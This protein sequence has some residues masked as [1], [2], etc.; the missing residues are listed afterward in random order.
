MDR[1]SCLPEELTCEIIRH[2]AHQSLPALVSI[3]RQFHRLVTPQLYRCVYFDGFKRT[4]VYDDYPFCANYSSAVRSAHRDRS[5]WEP[6]RICGLISFYKTILKNPHLRSYITVACFKRYGTSRWAMDNDVLNTDDIVFDILDL[7]P[8]LQTLEVSLVSYRFKPKIGVAL[9]SLKITHNLWA[10][11]DPE[12]TYLYS[13]F[14]IETLRNISIGNVAGRDMYPLSHRPQHPL[15]LATS[16][17]I[18]LSFPTGVPLGDDLAEF[19]LWPKALEVFELGSPRVCYDLILEN[20]I[21]PRKLAEVLSHH[22]HSLRELCITEYPWRFCSAE[23]D[24]A[25]MGNLQNFSVL[26]RLC[27]SMELMVVSTL[28]LY[29]WLGFEDN[30]SGPQVWESLPP[31][32]EE[33]IIRT[34]MQS[35]WQGQ[36]NLPDTDVIGELVMRLREITKHKELKYPALHEIVVWQSRLPTAFETLAAKKLRNSPGLLEDLKKSGIRVFISRD[37]RARALRRTELI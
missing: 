28:H 21:S 1:L 33:L 6:S 37:P 32:I 19:L 20:S 11:R 24:N 16:N 4:K 15:R 7:L 3:S 13:L 25:T 8:S 31:A 34:D 26:S 35:Q 9:K 2:V 14:L 36:S 18:S 10:R 29:T 12:N 27:V 5:R 30:Q 17:V 23:L 22:H